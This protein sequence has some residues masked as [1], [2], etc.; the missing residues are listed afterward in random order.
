M[1]RGQLKYRKRGGG[2]RGGDIP[3]GRG[4]GR[5]AASIESS[6]GESR[7]TATCLC[8]RTQLMF[9]PSQRSLSPTTSCCGCSYV[10]CR[11][12]YQGVYRGGRMLSILVA[13]LL[14]HS[15]CTASLS[16]VRK[17]RQGDRIA[18]L[19]RECRSSMSCAWHTPTTA[20]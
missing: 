16:Y 14:A 5:N 9:S 7:E 3:G 11:L 2:G 20:V 18:A 19:S 10:V 1:G 6:S 17:V 4:P 15:C 12:Y 8:S 13:L